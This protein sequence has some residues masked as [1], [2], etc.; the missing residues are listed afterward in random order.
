MDQ[1]QFQKCL[2]NLVDPDQT[3]QFEAVNA[4]NG[5]IEADILLYLYYFV[6][7]L[8]DE[9]LTPT[10]VFYCIRF[11][12]EAIKP[13]KGVDLK[14]IQEV[15]FDESNLALTN[16]I[17]D[18]F[19]RRLNAEEDFISNISALGV[20]Y[21]FNI[22]RERWVNLL[23]IFVDGLNSPDSSINYKKGILSSMIEILAL[24]I[25]TPSMPLELLPIELKTIT[26]F[27]IDYF[28]CPDLPIPFLKTLVQCMINLVRNIPVIFD[29]D[30]FSCLLKNIPNMLGVP[31]SELY[32]KSYDLLYV[33]YI[34]YYEII[35]DESLQIFYDYEYKG[36]ETVTLEYNTITL[37]FWEQI[38]KYEKI[39]EKKYQEIAR[40]ISIIGDTIQD[41]FPRILSF[42]I[43]ID[44]EQSEN[45]IDP[46]HS[47]AVFMGLT[48]Q[49]MKF[50]I[51][52]ILD[53][54]LEF[55]D[56][57]LGSD[58]INLLYASLYLIGAISYS[59]VVNT[60]RDDITARYFDRI[61]ELTY[62]PNYYI[63][64]S[65]CDCICLILKSN[66]EIL[67]YHNRSDLIIDRFNNILEDN[68]KVLIS[69]L[70]VMNF[71]INHSKIQVINDFYQSVCEILPNLL[72][73]SKL[74]DHDLITS[75]SR[76]YIS[77][78]EKITT[79]PVESIIELMIFS[80]NYI[81]QHLDTFQ[82]DSKISEHR[83]INML[84]VLFVI[85]Q[86]LRK[87]IL[88]I[89]PSIMELFQQCLSYQ[90]EILYSEVLSHYSNLI[91]HLGEEMMPYFQKLM[92]IAEL[93]FSISSPA[94]INAAIYVVGDLYIRAAPMDYQI[95]IDP[96]NSMLEILSKY[97]QN[98]I[99]PLIPSIIITI[100]DIIVNKGD[101][102]PNELLLIFYQDVDKI[103]N[104]PFDFTDINDRDNGTKI[105]VSCFH[106]YKIFFKIKST[107]EEI[108]NNQ[109]Y[110]SLATEL[111]K[112]IQICYNFEIFDEML[113]TSI[114]L[115]LKSVG[116]TFGAKISLKLNARYI[117]KLLNQGME[118]DN[119]E[120]KKICK[121][122]LKFL[123]TCNNKYIRH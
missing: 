64:S 108:Y 96:I 6:T 102:F 115:F 20:A 106:A 65:A 109:E 12:N 57:S 90:N 33:L 23:S 116:V 51:D 84:N 101:I 9:S 41:M 59:D 45:E 71:F 76:V 114:C 16:N 74:D 48:R 81:K 29:F 52:F 91:I 93:G 56:N 117:K 83:L 17:K 88:P 86:K 89:L 63:L 19:L 31:D 119:E 103:F 7:T 111:M 87:Q 67:M 60:K 85:I 73:N 94:I 75:I 21:V 49:F 99:Q 97:K 30:M 61:M 121:D 55:I 62:H 36:L 8:S 46:F 5:L 37:E 82:N 43:S 80:M 34:T 118:S 1:D 35:P 68:P 22:E 27:L 47:E 28:E 58:N 112:K 72:N 44:P 113:I 66:K 50:D 105:Y 25:F 78:V 69:L 122:T 92:D 107:Y 38:A 39:A 54:S 18:C 26:V 40:T 24:S 3:I 77:L 98:E 42:M 53:S 123:K 79:V 4:L 104:Y 95:L 14:A 32:F 11:I 70:K 110:F 13:T 100:S 120:L 15:W 2:L 10:I